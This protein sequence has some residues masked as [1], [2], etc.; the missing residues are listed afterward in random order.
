MAEFEAD[1]VKGHQRTLSQVAGLVVFPG[2]VVVAGILAGLAERKLEMDG[3]ALRQVLPPELLLHGSNLFR[4][5]PEHLEVRHAPVDLAEVGLHARSRRDI[6]AAPPAVGP[7][8]S[9]RAHS[10]CGCPGSA[11]LQGD[12]TGIG[13]RTLLHFANLR[14]VR[15]KSRPRARVRRAPVPLRAGSTQSPP[16]DG[17]SHGA[18]SR[19]ASRLPRARAQVPSPGATTPRC[20]TGAGHRPT[21]PARAYASHPRCPG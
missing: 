20:P 2:A 9:A 14:V 18:A 15:A 11:G 10:S 17:P 8:P 3:R 21:R 6:R 4:L 16:R 5:E 12:R 19:A 13:R 1:R 7:G